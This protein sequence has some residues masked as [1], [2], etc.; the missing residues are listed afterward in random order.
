MISETLAGTYTVVGS[1][2][3]KK[4]FPD[5]EADSG[6]YEDYPN[7]IRASDW[8]ADSD[9]L[10]NWYESIIGTDINSSVDDFSDANADDDL[11]GYTNLD[12]YLQ[13]MDKPNFGTETGEP[14]NINLRKLSRGFTSGVSYSI[15][16]VVNGTYNLSGD[17]VEFTP[18]SAGLGSFDFTVTDSDGD[19]MTR[20]VNIL[21]GYDLDVPVKIIP[22]SQIK[23]YP[24]P[25]NG[26]F[27]IEMENSS[28]K[29]IF[30]IFDISG[31]EILA[32]NIEAGATQNVSLK[33]QGVFILKIFAADSKQVIHTQKIITH[34]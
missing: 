20:T 13:W 11:D 6:G 4:G 22:T 27:F 19:S 7:I 9:G 16:N 21:I 3:G 18:T 2:T 15:T 12:D 34:Q 33:T 8:D 5:D 25:S 28:P 24:V 26:E 31:K 1:V 32:G 17:M 23:V 14:L 10:P 30:K 29:S